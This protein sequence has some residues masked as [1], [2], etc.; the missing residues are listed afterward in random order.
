MPNVIAPG[1][2]ALVG[3]AE[4][5]PGN[6]PQDE[7]LVRAAAGGPAFVVATAAAR[8]RPELAVENAVRWFGN[9][10]LEVEEL[11]ARRR[12]DA[13]SSANAERA[14]AGRFF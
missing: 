7:I 1:P 6:E 12:S 8:Q 9:L 13:T 10:G 3:G 11:P 14:S 5:Q 4:L 2:L